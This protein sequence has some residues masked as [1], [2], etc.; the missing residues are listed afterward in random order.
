M[1]LKRFDTTV[2]RSGE[3]HTLS[4]S[5]N[6]KTGLFCFSRK[7]AEQYKMC[8]DQRVVLYQDKKNPADW[9]FELTN[10]T[11]GFLLRFQKEMF[12]TFSSRAMALE[13]FKSLKIDS[14]GCSFKLAGEST[15]D[16]GKLMYAIITSSA[17][18]R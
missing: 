9:Y 16:A 3:K 1:E 11:T 2:I 6:T 14:R 7:C 4:L 13:L 15:A 5:V 8:P 18:K 17:K 10:E 12:Y